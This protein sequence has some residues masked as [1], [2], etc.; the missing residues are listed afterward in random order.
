MVRV[1]GVNGAIA[2]L[3]SVGL[4]GWVRFAKRELRHQPFQQ[5]V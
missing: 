4:S 3:V 1:A 2:L 5:L